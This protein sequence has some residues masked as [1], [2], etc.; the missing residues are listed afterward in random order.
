MKV[1]TYNTLFAGFD[2]VDNRRQKLQH[3]VIRELQPDVLLIQ[4]AKAFDANGHKLLFQTEDALGL[5]GLL[6]IAPHTGQNTAIFFRP[7]IKPV[8][9]E[10]DAVHFHHVASAAQLLVPGFSVPITF[11]SVHLAPTNP[12]VR[13][14]EAAY[15]IAH[16]APEKL[17]LVAG[18]F[19]SVSSHDPEPQGWEKLPT[20]FRA[21][22]LPP[23]SETA[24]RE[25]LRTLY[26]AGF[27]DVAHRLGKN[28]M[29]TVPGADFASA[30]FIP[31]RCD[32]VLA[33]VS[34]AESAKS[35]EVLKDART[36]SASDHYPILAEFAA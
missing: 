18:D 31:F 36:G 27:V 17:T 7:E 1:L 19:N 6:G 9:F 14:R 10:M 21:R 25:T 11:V 4:E 24:D 13:R 28:G 30:E 35:Y 16:A 33:S 8:A 34:L 29:T 2:G 26:S 22:Y 12:E 23:G 32:H 3:E 5:R 20:H 15:L